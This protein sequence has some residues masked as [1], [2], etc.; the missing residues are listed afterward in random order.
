MPPVCRP[1]QLTSLVFRAQGNQT[2]HDSGT[3]RR[4]PHAQ[5]FDVGLRKPQ[6]LLKPWIRYG[7]S[8]IYGLEYI[9]KSNFI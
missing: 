1:S 9:G 2:G 5:L 7:I 3:V 4:I 8:N 6:Q